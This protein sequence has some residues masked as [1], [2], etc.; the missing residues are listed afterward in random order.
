[1]WK[2]SPLSLRDA[3]AVRNSTAHCMFADVPSSDDEPDLT[4]DWP[5]SAR[6]KVRGGLQS[7]RP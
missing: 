4:G 2:K 6:H 3:A 1:M 7:A 5:K